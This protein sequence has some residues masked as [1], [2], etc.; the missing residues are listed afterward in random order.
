MSALLE[1]LADSLA[2]EEVACGRAWLISKQTNDSVTTA[3]LRSMK[4]RITKL[5]KDLD[6]LIG[7]ME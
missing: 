7:E 6:T 5:A 2:E 1:A 3:E 4:R